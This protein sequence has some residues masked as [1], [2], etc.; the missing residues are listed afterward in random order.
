MAANVDPMYRSTSLA[1]IV[2]YPLPY[3]HSFPTSVVEHPTSAVLINRGVV[4][5]IKF[6]AS[7]RQRGCQKRSKSVGFIATCLLSTLFTGVIVGRAAKAVNDQL[8]Q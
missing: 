5:F 8:H 2:G 3:T 4:D 6:Q 7:M 1:L